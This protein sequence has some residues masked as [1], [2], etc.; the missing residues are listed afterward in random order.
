[1]KTPHTP[2]QPSDPTGFDQLHE[3]STSFTFGEHVF[4]VVPSYEVPG[5]PWFVLNQVVDFLNL[6]GN[7]NKILKGVSASDVA[8]ARL[9][10]ESRGMQTMR[11]INEPTLYRLIFRS[12]K[13]QAKAFQD[14]ILHGVLPAIRRDDQYQ[15]Q[16]SS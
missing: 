16:P 1:M 12:R 11:V 8:F 14:Y 10:T 7:A 4:T 5:G 3:T 13:P 9:P 6:T 15:T 2:Q